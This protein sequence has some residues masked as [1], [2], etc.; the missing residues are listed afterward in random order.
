LGRS[1]LSELAQLGQQSLLFLDNIHIFWI[2][3][4][5]IKV[6]LG[7]GVLDTLLLFQ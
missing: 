5:L 1:G 3:N 2:M 4:V 7:K 6:V